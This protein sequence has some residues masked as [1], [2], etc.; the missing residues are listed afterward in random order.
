MISQI[1]VYIMV[2]FMAVAAID[3]MFGNRLGLGQ[4]FEEGFNAMGALTLGM[5]GIMVTVDLIGAVLTPTVGALFS[6]IGADPSM[7]GSLIISIDTG[8]YA[9]AHAIQ[10][11]NADIAN[12]SAIILASMMGP[13]IAFGIPVCLG[14]M[15][16]SDKRF[17][18]IGT[19]SGIV[20][21]PVSYTHLDV[22][23]RQVQSV[24]HSIS[25]ISHFKH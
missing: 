14:I 13:T 9:L 19:M 2:I 23:K 3:R 8:G 1:I 10:P 21:I 18:A 15:Q 22:Y 25:P 4:E 7:A 5:A 12:F 17:L 11:Y 6:A 16:P 20:C 24:A